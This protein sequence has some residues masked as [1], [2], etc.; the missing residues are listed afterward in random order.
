M[1]KLDSIPP[2]LTY[3]TASHFDPST[4]SGQRRG[5]ANRL[6]I[7]FPASAGD[8]PNQSHRIWEIARSAG[9]NVLLLSLCSDYYEESQLR[10]QLVSMAAMISDSNVC[11]DIRIEHG[12]D[13]VGQVRNI[14]QPG[15]VIACY[16][17][18]RV[19]LRG[20]VL[21]DVLRSQLEAPI[22]ILS[23]DQP[24][25]NSRSKSLL[26]ASFWSGALAIIGGFLWLEVKLVQLPQDWTHNLLLYLCV[27]VEIGL[28]VLWNSIFT[29]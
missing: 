18:Q 17:G 23:V 27:F 22:Y 1:T 19:G 25:K 7:L 2:P 15:D 5:P 9:L 29:Q 4:G 6:I 20:R 24:I 10:R 8:N 28:L 14:Y 26:Q 13:W 3:S 21:H 16:A 12:N 11:A